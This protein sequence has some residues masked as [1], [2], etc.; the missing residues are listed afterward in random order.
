MPNYTEVLLILGVYE[1]GEEQVTEFNQRLQQLKG[2]SAAPLVRVATPGMFTTP[3]YAGCLT[4]LMT[5]ELVRE[6]N[7]IPWKDRGAGTFL[8]VNDEGGAGV[9]ERFPRVG[10]L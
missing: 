4:R 2:L 1:T 8:L 7:A 9:F 10:D 6:F 3:V 5:S